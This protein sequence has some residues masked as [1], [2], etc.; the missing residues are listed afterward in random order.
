[1]SLFLFFVRAKDRG[2]RNSGV[3]DNKR[4]LALRRSVAGLAVVAVHL[5]STSYRAEKDRLGSAE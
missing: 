4:S 2:K 1:M 3:G 5:E